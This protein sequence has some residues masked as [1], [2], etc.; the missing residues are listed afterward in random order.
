MHGK[1]AQVLGQV[2][3]DHIAGAVFIIVLDKLSYIPQENHLLATCKAGTLDVIS[4]S[5][6]LFDIASGLGL[7][8]FFGLLKR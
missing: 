6:A 7:Q 8:R 1:L 2:S 5:S 4:C 3:G